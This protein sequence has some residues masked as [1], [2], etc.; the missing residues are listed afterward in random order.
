MTRG[1]QGVGEQGHRRNGKRME[2][3][4]GFGYKCDF[5]LGTGLV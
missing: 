4:S 1:G 2:K 3:E 5:D